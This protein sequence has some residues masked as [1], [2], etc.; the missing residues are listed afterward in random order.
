MKSRETMGDRLLLG[1]LTVVVAVLY[2][3]YRLWAAA[4][5]GLDEWRAS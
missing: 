1:S 2:Q 5:E 3:P 4:R